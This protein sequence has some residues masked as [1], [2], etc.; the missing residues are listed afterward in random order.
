MEIGSY[1]YTQASGDVPLPSGGE[2][3]VYIK[4]PDNVQVD[5]IG[6]AIEMSVQT[7][8]AQYISVCNA[9][10]SATQ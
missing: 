1:N 2:L 6:T 7:S 10:A 4:D 3:L 8:R 5:D 9:R